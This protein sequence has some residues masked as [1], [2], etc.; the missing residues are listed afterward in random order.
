[1]AVVDYTAEIEKSCVALR[2]ARK[3]KAFEREKEMLELEQ[4]RYKLYWSQIHDWLAPKRNDKCEQEIRRLVKEVFTLDLPVCEIKIKQFRDAIDKAKGKKDDKTIDVYYQ[5]LQEWLQ[6]YEDN[7]ALTSFRILENF[8]LFMEWEKRE[9]VWQP[10]LDPYGDGGYTGVSKPF[11]FYFNQMV[12]KKD[13]KFISKQMFTGGGKSYSN[14]FAIA[15]LMGVDINNDVLDV[16][17]NPSLVLTNTK[18]IVEIVKNPRYVKVF[19]Q[20]EKYLVRV[21]GKG[22]E[23]ILSV[24]DDIFSTCSIK[25]G[26]LTFADSDK[27]LNIRIISK[28]TPIDGVRVRYLFL[29]DICRAKDAA[30]LKQHTIDIELFWNSWW[31]RNYGTDDFYIIISG[32]AYNVADIMSHLIG[33]YSKG[34]MQRTKEFKYAYKSLDGSCAFIKIPKIDDELDRSTYPQK[35]PYEEAIRIRE[36][37]YNSFMAMEQ[38]QPQNPETSPLCY[39]KLLTYEKLPSNMSEYSYACLDPAR[40]GKNFVTMGIHRVCK[41]IDKFNEPIERHYLV[42][43]VFQLKQMADLY[44]EICDKIEKH[45]V[46]KLHIENNTDTSLKFLLEKML[47]E[48]KIYT[49][50]ISEKFSSENKEEKMRELVY[51]NEGYFKNILVYPAMNMYAASSE[52]GKFMLYLTAYDYYQKLEYDDSIDEE[53]MYIDKFVVNRSKCEKARIIH[54]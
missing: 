46:T 23:E 41:E 31:K 9:K 12:L 32:T 10:S 21:K 3:S 15:W 13:I 40:T 27:P 4:L 24:S 7:Y 14:Q 34:K 17:G 5:Y 54:L 37:D 45:N 1:M 49:C 52:M 47:H 26:K 2:K 22:G 43:C 53:C 28:D 6:L 19:P 51:A 8:C 18:G 11:F 25:D 38:Q 33:Y 35:F 44:G 50:E 36:R 16:L 42:D 39:E 48:R 29:D 30:N 20:F